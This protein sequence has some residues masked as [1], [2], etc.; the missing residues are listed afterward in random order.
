[1][2]AAGWRF[3]R[4]GKTHEIRPDLNF[5]K[6][7]QFSDRNDF[8]SKQFISREIATDK[9]MDKLEKSKFL[10]SILAYST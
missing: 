3:K 4:H 2:G 8:A 5:G 1:M 9:Q 7:E 10:N 6:T